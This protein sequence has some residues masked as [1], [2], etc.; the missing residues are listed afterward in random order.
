MRRFLPRWWIWPLCS[1]SCPPPLPYSSSTFLCW[2]S[3]FSRICCPPFNLFPFLPL[4]LSL[5]PSHHLFLTILLRTLPPRAH[6]LLVSLSPLLF[7]SQTEYQGAARMGYRLCVCVCVCVCGKLSLR[8]CLH[9]PHKSP[10]PPF[11]LLGKHNGCLSS[12]PAADTEQIDPLAYLF[13]HSRSLCITSVSSSWLNQAMPK[14]NKIP[15][16]R[17]FLKWNRSYSRRF[18]EF[19]SGISYQF[20]GGLRQTGNSYKMG[21]F[22]AIWRR[23]I[24]KHQPKPDCLSLLMGGKKPTFSKQE[25]IKHF[26]PRVPP[27]VWSSRAWIRVKEKACT[28]LFFLFLERLIFNSAA[29]SSRISFFFFF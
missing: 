29:C 19:Y 18:V 2:Y 9:N 25:G 24:L 14:S 20:G 23:I 12:I 1:P 7:V 4:S 8:G 11:G 13:K 27:A 26:R 10:H 17:I 6:F 22:I 3:S 21:H 16:S 5:S 28:D 15:P